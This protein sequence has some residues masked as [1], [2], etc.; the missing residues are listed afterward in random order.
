MAQTWVNESRRKNSFYRLQDTASGISPAISHF[1][2]KYNLLAADGPDHN[3]TFRVG[4]LI[5]GEQV[6]V[7]V[8]RSKKEAEQAAAQKALAMVAKGYGQ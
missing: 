7:G 6:A 3:K 8:G 1:S 5:N 4:V 2:L